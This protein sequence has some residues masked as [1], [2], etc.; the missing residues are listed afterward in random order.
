MAYLMAFSLLLLLKSVTSSGAGCTICDGNNS[1]CVDGEC[2]PRCINLTSSGECLQC[3]DSRFHG[4]QCKNMCP[5]TCINSRCQINN[6]RVVCT[7]GCVAGK[8][9]DNCGVNC[10][11]ACTQCERYGDGCTGQCSNSRYYG[12]NCR[13][14]CPSNCR[15]GCDKETGE[16]DSCEEGYR[17]KYCKEDCPISCVGG[18]EKDTG[19]CDSCERGN[20]GK[21]CNGTCKSGLCKSGGCV[22]DMVECSKCRR[23]VRGKYCNAFCPST[24]THCERY[25]VECTGQCSESQY[26]GLSCQFPC[27]AHCTGGCDSDTG[28]CTNCLAGYRGEFCNVTCPS[29]CS[30]CQRFGDVCLGPCPHNEHYGE[31]CS[32]PCPVGCA[33]C[34]KVTGICLSCA[35]LFKRTYCNELCTKCNGADCH[36]T[37]CVSRNTEDAH[38]TLKIICGLL[39]VLALMCG[40]FAGMRHMKIRRER[41]IFSSPQHYDNQPHGSNGPRQSDGDYWTKKYWEIYDN[42]MDSDQ[43][44]KRSTAK[45]SNGAPQELVS[46]RTAPLNR[47]SSS[48]LRHEDSA[49]L[50]NLDSNCSYEGYECVLAGPEEADGGGDYT[51]IHGKDAMTP[52]ISASG[53]CSSSSSDISEACLPSDAQLIKKTDSIIFIEQNCDLASV[54]VSYLSPDNADAEEEC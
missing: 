44:V 46:R 39:A 18:C 7:E 30:Q 24:C 38:L 1:T 53:E 13:K 31:D 37:P 5:D 42:D 50:N 19:H 47:G 4:E 8:K 20:R 45:Q 41:T 26:Y 9:G 22:E 51:N 15:E 32:T 36:T 52:Q 28:K 6:S 43:S 10:S 54:S 14:S 16:C 27:P 2:L 25:G 12:L 17:G 3:R 49:L 29:N 21:F 23:G 35:S 11:S 33:G 40:A 48:D 34:N